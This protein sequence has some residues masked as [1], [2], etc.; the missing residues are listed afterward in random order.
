MTSLYS[1][2]ARVAANTKYFDVI[3]L[4]LISSYVDA[5]ISESE[6]VNEMEEKTRLFKDYSIIF[7]SEE[8][9]LLL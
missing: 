8:S 1:P 6:E 3:A 9:S 2:Y 5:G 7:G 4:S